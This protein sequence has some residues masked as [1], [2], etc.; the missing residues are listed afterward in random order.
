MV[1]IS[2]FSFPYSKLR[3]GQGQFIKDVY[4]TIEEKKT[5]LVNAP[6]G[7]GKTIC[8][9]APSLY[10]AI[11]YNKK[12]I[13]LTSRQ[14]QVNQVLKTISQINQKREEE[15]KQSLKATTFIGKKNMCYKEIN[16]D[17]P[18]P[19]LKCK[20]AKTPGKCSQCK[21]TKNQIEYEDLSEMLGDLSCIEDFMRICRSEGFCPYTVA[22]LE[23]RKSDIIVC[24]VNYVFI[25]SISLGFFSTLGVDLS[26]CIIIADEAHN[27]PDRIR[28]SYSYSISTQTL[29]FAKE[30]F[31]L[32][33]FDCSKQKLILSH[34][35]KTLEILYSSK[36]EFNTYEYHIE[37]NE[38][39]YQ[40]ESSLGHDIKPKDV[41]EKLVEVEDFLL[42]KE[43]KS[44]SWCG[45]ISRAIEEIYDFKPQKY[46][47]TLE[48]TN[49]KGVEH[50]SV[51]LQ[52]LDIAQYI[53]PIFNES[54]SSIIM[55]ATLTPLN[56]FRDVMGVIEANTLELKSPFMSERQMI[57]IDDEITTQFSQRSSQMF[58]KIALRLEEY[59]ITATSRNALIFFPSYSFM[60]KVVDEMHLLRLNRK[61]LKEKR[62]MSQDD[63][64]DMIRKFKTQGINTNSHVL[65]AVTTGS[66][67]E[68]INLPKEAL[69]M[70][71]VV[72]VPL[73]VPDLFTKS[74][75]R[76]YERKYKK[77]Q[78][79]GYIAPAIS[80]IVQAAGRCIRTDEDKGVVILMDLRFMWPQYAINYPNQWRLLKRTP[81]T[82]QEIEDFFEQE[83]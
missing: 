5:I 36:K 40:F 64:N 46:V 39:L 68:G 71:I 73:G 54:F 29:Q 11:Q 58:S 23:M 78:L 83:I 70:V 69:E 26:E 66:F 57:V 35:K 24:D 3:P 20:K 75:M 30:E 82:P 52:C 6:T 15:N 10:Q 1:K 17:N 13:Y 22:Q 43:L 47:F 50:F 60:Q 16:A 18:D 55:S 8:S 81:N 33:E 56:M 2:D 44:Q 38:F 4:K 74:L 37:K 59:L 12:V 61:I 42:R 77:G 34:I 80:K 79:Y 41:I 21:N 31:A 27:L 25:S 67:S 14:T 76:F 62:G 7:L 9:L 63:K 49:Q 48:L 28:N 72:G 65:F 32:C 45:S 19:S 51:K 53:S